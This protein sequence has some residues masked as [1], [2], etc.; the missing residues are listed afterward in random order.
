MSETENLFIREISL[1]GEENFYSLQRAKVAVIGLGGVGSYVAEALVRAGVGQLF[2]CDNDVIA[3]HNINRQLFALHSTIGK[4][5]ADVAAERLKDI[6]PNIVITA[7]K[8]RF[9]K[10]NLSEFDF[11]GYDYVVDCIDLVTH[12]LLLIQL[13]KDI[14]VPIICSMGTGNKLDCKFE[15]ADIFDT[16][17]C[18]LS[19]VMRK[20]LRRRN[21]TN[22]KVVYSEEVAKKPL[23][24]NNDEIRRQTPSSIS[25]VPALAGLLIAS[26]VIKDII[27]NKQAEKNSDNKSEK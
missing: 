18:P 25:Y 24:S 4:Y 6:N 26:E 9:D 20:E 21:I 13:A 7:K 14:G 8:I 1:I 19:A 17:I 12:K 2:L 23:V 22:V 5:K 11:S 10:D 3:R 15:V 16:K 27:G